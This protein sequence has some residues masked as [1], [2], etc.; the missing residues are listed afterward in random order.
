MICEGSICWSPKMGRCY[1]RLGCIRNGYAFDCNRMGRLNVTYRRCATV[2]ISRDH[3]SRRLEE[4]T[5]RSCPV[6]PQGLWDRIW[7]LNKGGFLDHRSHSRSEDEPEIWV[8][9]RTA[10][11]VV[12]NIRPSTRKRYSAAGSCWKACVARRASPSC[13]GASWRCASPT[14][15]ATSSPKPRSIAC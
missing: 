3:H 14:R 6:R 11:K 13:A 7:L 4:H 2:Y 15:P 12:Q 8:G 1:G 10:E 9:E 5:V